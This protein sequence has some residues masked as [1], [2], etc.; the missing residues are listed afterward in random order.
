MENLFAADIALHLLGDS[1]SLVIAT[2]AACSHRASVLRTCL[3]GPTLYYLVYTRTLY[4]LQP[5]EFLLHM[6]SLAFVSTIEI[7]L[8][9][10]FFSFR[11]TPLFPG[12]VTLVVIRWIH[13]IWYPTATSVVVFGAFVASARWAGLLSRRLPNVKS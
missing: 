9:M 10:G 11:L 12:A 1:V 8:F 2:H 3:L 13:T 4:R 6:C 5:L 7:Y